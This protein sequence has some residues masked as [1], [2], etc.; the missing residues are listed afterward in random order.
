[1]KYFTSDLHFDHPYVAALRGYITDHTPIEEIRT[2]PLQERYRHVDVDAHDHMLLDRLLTLGKQDE[3]WILGDIA[4]GSA[5][6]RLK[7]V[8]L[9]DQLHVPRKHRHLILGNHENGMHPNGPAMAD[10][11]RVF[12]EIAVSGVTTVHDCMGIP[13]TVTLSHFPLLRSFQRGIVPDGC[14][15]NSLDQKWVAYALPD[16]TNFH[17]HGHTHAKTPFEFPDDDDQINVGVDA[18]AGRPVSEQ[19]IIGLYLSADRKPHLSLSR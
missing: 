6:S 16:P 10:W 8:R 7:A 15:P 9:L 11:G 12:S 4:S 19:D 2:M 13:V 18:W 1:M 3:L 17:L 5:A 14:A